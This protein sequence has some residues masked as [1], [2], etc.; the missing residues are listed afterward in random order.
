MSGDP[1][2]SAQPMASTPCYGTTA[3]A[4][5][6]VVFV[7]VL[8]V[9]ILGLLHDD[10][11]KATQSFWINIHAVLGILLWGTVLARLAWR[12]GHLPPPLP[13]DVGSMAKRLSSP[14]HLTLYALL[15][16]TPLI[17]VVTFVYH[18]R[19]FDFGIFQLDPGI[20]KNRAVFKPTENIHE[21][22]AY[23]LFTLAG[24]HAAAALWHALYLRDG[25]LRR[26]WPL[27]SG[28]SVHCGK[29]CGDSP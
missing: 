12:L 20:Q 4:F 2:E 1:L 6:W 22:L 7:F 14:V 17:G 15:L 19:I 25:V 29:G 24:L 10:W 28:R 21:Y 27:K 8:I 11:P 16:A 3:I 18:G 26:M 23:A 5:H 9:G 13:G